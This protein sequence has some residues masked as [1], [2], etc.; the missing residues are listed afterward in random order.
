MKS[1]NLKQF[2]SMLMNPNPIVEFE[3]IHNYEKELRIANLRT[4]MRIYKKKNKE[5]YKSLHREYLE[6]I[7]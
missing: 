2:E 4:L 3:T 7:R 5:I 6:L 1:I